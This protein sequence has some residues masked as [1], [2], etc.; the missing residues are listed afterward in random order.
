MIGRR[1]ELPI[2]AFSLKAYQVL[3]ATY[4]AKFR[5]EYG[6]HMVQVFRDCCLRAIRQSG[7]N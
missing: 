5:Q 1:A 6:S 7:P 4:P 2:M 3:L